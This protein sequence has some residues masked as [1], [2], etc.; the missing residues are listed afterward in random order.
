MQDPRIFYR[1]QI[2][3]SKGQLAKVREQLYASSMVRLVVFCIA[4]FG[5]YLS[6]GEIKLVLGLL[7]A[8]IVVFIY[9]V[10]RHSD[11]QYKKNKVGALLKIN[12]TELKVLDQEYLQ[13][14]DGTEYKNPHH[15]FSQDIDLFGRGSFFQYVN[16]TELNCHFGENGNPI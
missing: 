14:P 12:E 11:L 16:R 4:G 5:I 6:F 15:Y 8:F 9:L 13:L 10:S 1:E 7:L 3:E 2:T